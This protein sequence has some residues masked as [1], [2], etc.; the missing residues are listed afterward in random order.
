MTAIL[1]HSQTPMVQSTGE[2]N[3]VWYRFMATFLRAFGNSSTTA[4]TGLSL[5]NGAFSIAENGV[6]NDKLRQSLPLSVIGC[7]LNVEANP[8]DIQ[9]ADN[10]RFL[11][12][13]NDQIVFRVPRF[14][15]YAVADLPAASDL[16]AGTR[17]FVSDATVTT[18]ASIVAG[19]GSNFVPV[20]S[21]GTNWRIG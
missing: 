9:A 16:G 3:P 19:G 10:G 4:S 2:M 8:Q 7:P 21:D 6:T 12:R 15:V 17:V 14:P 18:F 5:T 20:F 11:Q 13:D 1:P